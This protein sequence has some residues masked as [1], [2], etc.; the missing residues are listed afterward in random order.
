[1]LLRCNEMYNFV[2]EKYTDDVVV[3]GIIRYL[4]IVRCLDVTTAYIRNIFIFARGDCLCVIETFILYLYLKCKRF[5]FY[6]P[7]LFLEHFRLDKGFSFILLWQGET[8]RRSL[9]NLVEN[10]SLF[11]KNIY[12]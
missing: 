10:F 7:E 8:K 11:L 12:C 5:L 1:M 2:D 9:H 6:T 4:G 3:Q